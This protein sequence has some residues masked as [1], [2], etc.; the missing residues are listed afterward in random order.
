MITGA[1]RGLGLEFARQYGA[2]GWTVLAT[3]RN[4]VG[5]GEL[6]TIAG[7][8]QVYGLDVTD[9]AQI[10]R[11]AGELSGVAMDV[12]IN[13]AGIYGPRMN[14]ADAVDYDQW[15][16]VMETNVLSPLKV[17]TAFTPHV[18]AG[19]LKTIAT[20]TSKMGSI[21]DNT[22]GGAYIYRSSKAAVN[23]VMRSLAWDL[24][25]QGINVILLHPGWVKTDMGGSNALI[26]AETSVSGLR[27]VIAETG[28]REAGHFFNYDGAP[29]PW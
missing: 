22:S 26:D 2:E 17:T 23:A 10:D 4:P 13:N 29:I 19:N 7:D 9:H 16:Q 20:L 14:D 25:P 27:R 18:A 5:V 28:P 11:L 24:N 21:A 6:A 3:C 8:I 1:S 15:R 12:L